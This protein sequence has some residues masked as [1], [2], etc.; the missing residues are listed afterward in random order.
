MKPMLNEG[1]QI[2]NL[3]C[4]YENFFLFHF[5]TV[6]GPLHC[7]RRFTMYI[8]LPVS[9]WEYPWVYPTCNW[10]FKK[11]GG[12]TKLNFQFCIKYKNASN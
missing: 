4:V 1:N 7:F 10:A 12:T 2:H 3:N 6:K 5:I 11:K 8:F 9:G